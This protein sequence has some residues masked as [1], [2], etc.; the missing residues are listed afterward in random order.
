M[1]S[2]A[3]PKQAAIIIT[4]IVII[5]NII[6]IIIIIPIT[7]KTN[8]FMAVTIHR[9]KYYSVINNLIFYL[10]SFPVIPYYYYHGPKLPHPIVIN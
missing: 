9:F 4:I 7:I 10:M 5:I 8:F 2:L 1:T 6:I 3:D